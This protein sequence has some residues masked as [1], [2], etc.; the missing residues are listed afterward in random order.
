MICPNSKKRKECVYYYIENGAD[1]CGKYK[2]YL[3]K[4]NFK[5]DY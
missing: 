3:F 2:D 4:F 1:F 5:C